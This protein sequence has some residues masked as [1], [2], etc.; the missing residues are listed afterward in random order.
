[1]SKVLIVD[2][3]PGVSAA[4]ECFLMADGHAVRKAGS[5]EQALTFLRDDAPDVALLDIR[6][7]GIDGVAMLRQLRKISPK[8]KVIMVSAYLNRSLR[9]QVTRMGACACVQKPV[10]LFDLRSCVNQFLGSPDRRPLEPSAL[11]ATA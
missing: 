1:M 3:E 11:S 9:E 6:M 5:A 10:N 4:F 8:T 7:P 2:D